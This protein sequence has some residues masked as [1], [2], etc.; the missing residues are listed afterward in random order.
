MSKILSLAVVS[1]PEVSAE[2]AAWLDDLRGRFPGL[3]HAPLPPHVTLVFPTT[4]V[5]AA[6][7]TDHVGEVAQHFQPFDFVIRCALPMPD[8]L[9]SNTHVFLVPE[10][11]FSAMVRLHD[12]LYSGALASA[13]RLDIPF[14]PHITVGYGTDA[15]YCK[16]AADAINAENRTVKGTV[17]VLDVLAISEGGVQSIQRL[18]LRAR[19]SSHRAL[20]YQPCLFLFIPGR[21]RPTGI[22]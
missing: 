21:A 17:S 16:Q 3:A 15:A 20:S 11:G 13:L 18:P 6:A 9:S 7:L 5:D 4:A 22:P 1:S 10:E 2:D 8:V 12:R 14:V 19:C